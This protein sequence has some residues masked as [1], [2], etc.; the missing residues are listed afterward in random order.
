MPPGFQRLSLSYSEP[1][2][3]KHDWNVQRMRLLRQTDLASH[4]LCDARESSL[5]LILSLSAKWGNNGASRIGLS[6][7]KSLCSAWHIGVQYSVGIP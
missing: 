2:A 4:Q 3:T 1:P 5:L 7:N 6:E